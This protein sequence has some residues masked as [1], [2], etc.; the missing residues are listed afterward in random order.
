MTK[1]MAIIFAIRSFG[2]AYGSQV[3]VAPNSGLDQLVANPKVFKDMS[4]DEFASADW[5]KNCFDAVVVCKGE[6]TNA[7]TGITDKFVVLAVP[8]RSSEIPTALKDRLDK[9]E[10]H[11]AQYGHNDSYSAVIKKCR[12]GD[13]GDYDAS[14]N[15]FLQ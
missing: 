11:W 4:S 2:T 3:T 14:N 5:A 12:C 10:Q 7:S 15:L 8:T 9:L 6:K 1:L 13:P